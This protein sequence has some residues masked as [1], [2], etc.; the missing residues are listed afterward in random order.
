MVPLRSDLGED[1]AST[2]SGKRPQPRLVLHDFSDTTPAAAPRAPRSASALRRKSARRW[3]ALICTLAVA[4]VIGFFLTTFVVSAWRSGAAGSS[5][6]F[7]QASPV[8]S[9]R[10]GHGDTLWRYAARYGDPNS[11]IL[12]RVESL[13]RDNH[14]SSTTPLV[15]GQTLHIAVH[16]PVEIARLQRQH[17]ARVASR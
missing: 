16:N 2:W 4:A 17:Q 3:E 12:D 7:V 14:I 9:V 5:A 1:T 10:V 6:A 15:P 13:S 11:Y 8:I